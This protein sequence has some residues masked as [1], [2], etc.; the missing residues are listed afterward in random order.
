MG[1]NTYSEVV[2]P[3]INETNMLTVVRVHTNGIESYLNKCKSALKTMR[4]CRR[5][6]LQS[7]LNEFMW[8]DRF[9]NSAFDN[10]CLHMSNQYKLN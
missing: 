6:M 7:Y 9:D 10:L 4:G 5:I 1:S 8:R 3:L 2:Q